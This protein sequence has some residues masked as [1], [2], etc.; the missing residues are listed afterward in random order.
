MRLVSGVIPLV[1]AAALA[2]ITTSDAQ[3]SATARQA[4]RVLDRTYTCST[5][6]LGG[7]YRIETRA[8]AGLR[9]HGE[10]VNLPYAVVASGGVTRTPGV[11]APPSNS[12]AWVTAGTPSASTAV[13]ADWL[14]YT[15]RSGGTVGI[16]RAQCEP[17]RMRV[18]LVSTG[19]RGGRVSGEAQA[20]D[21]DTSRK[22]VIRLRATALASAPLRERAQIFLT[23][24]TP[25]RDAQ[26]AV[27]TPTGKLLAYAAVDQSGKAWQ[28]T[29]PNGCVRES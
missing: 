27:R 2:P 9:A 3:G 17:A 20:V 29:A 13:D 12:L 16:N 4:V 11:D 21:C 22:V 14:A 1:V 18:P 5:V 23:T 15:V 26:L 25:I 24:S 28:Y 6:L 7:L 8:H 10:W 19:L